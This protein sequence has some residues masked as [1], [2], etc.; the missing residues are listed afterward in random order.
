[1]TVSTEQLQHTLHWFA[2]IYL[3]VFES[4]DIR[5]YLR[6]H[7]SVKNVKVSGYFIIYIIHEY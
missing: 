6:E 2:N 1:M 3:L 7:S 4:M 5:K